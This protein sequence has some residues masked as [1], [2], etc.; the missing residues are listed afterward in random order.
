MNRPVSKPRRA[1]LYVLVLGAAMLVTLAGVSAMLVVRVQQRG[2]NEEQDFV[3]A[4]YLALSAI[5]RGLLAIASDP[6]WRSTRPNGLWLTN[7]P[8]GSGTFSLRGID[9]ADSNLS[10]CPCDPLVL[11][12]YGFQG[13]ATQ[14]LQ[15]T[16]TADAAN[17]DP[18]RDAIVSLGPV[19]YWRLGETG[20]TTAVDQTGQ[21]SGTYRNGVGLGVKVPLRCDTAVR[22]DGSNDYVEIPHNNAFL[23]NSGTIQ[24]WFCPDTVATTQGL[25]TKDS[26][27]FDTGG[28]VGFWIDWTQRV[29]VRLQ[30]TYNNYF[31]QSGPIS[32]GQWYHVAFTFGTGGMRLYLNGDLVGTDGYTGGL[33]TSSG[34][35]GNYEPLAI[36]VSTDESDD[37]S[38]SPYRYP[39]RGLIDEV[40]IF[41]KVLT[42][43][44]IKTLYDAGTATPPHTMRV[45][46]GS[47][48]RVVN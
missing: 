26:L 6:S 36:G 16:L 14:M 20:G 47:W 24:F 31:V 44:E 33:G 42:P 46:L 11:T 34:G 9:P 22:F 41:A 28:H 1:S 25:L 2:V 19:A 18:L 35:S 37:F 32:A 8:F 13:A 27:G 12:G 45:V 21:H 3:A 29:L 4:Q 38:I 5:D 10:D 43:A 39:Y 23:L 17:F 7:V 40:A 15:V 48:R 30:S